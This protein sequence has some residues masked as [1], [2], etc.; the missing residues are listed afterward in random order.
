MSNSVGSKISKHLEPRFEEFRNQLDVVEHP[1]TKEEFYQLMREQIMVYD[2]TI[3]GYWDFTC[4]IGLMVERDDKTRI[5]LDILFDKDR[6][7]RDFEDGKEVKIRIDKIKKP[8]RTWRDDLIDMQPIAR[9]LG[10]FCIDD[11]V[12]ACAS[13]GL[14]VSREKVEKFVKIAKEGGNCLLPEL[15]FIGPLNNFDAIG[16]IDEFVSNFVS[17]HIVPLYKSKYYADGPFSSS[18][19]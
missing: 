1:F 13:K 15:D 16:P 14:K 4:K 11:L 12:N 19:N 7:V 3:D 9:G 5:N 10:T 17:K 2:K 8:E 6:Y 18:D